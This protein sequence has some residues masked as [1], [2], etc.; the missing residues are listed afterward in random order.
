MEHCCSALYKCAPCNKINERKF[1]IS[2]SVNASIR[3]Y[4]N[5]HGPYVSYRYIHMHF[6]AL[7]K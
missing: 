5:G 6:L 4:E 3:H 1:T 7:L 2:N